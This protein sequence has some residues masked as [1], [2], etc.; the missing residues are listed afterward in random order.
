MSN[1][2]QLLTD[3]DVADFLR[4]STHRVLRLARN[5]EIPHFVLPSGEFR[6]IAAEILNWIL[7][8]RADRISRAKTLQE[9]PLAISSGKYSGLRDIK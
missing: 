5:N 8:R 3:H 4:I 9:K 7:D 1:E 6:F 2:Q